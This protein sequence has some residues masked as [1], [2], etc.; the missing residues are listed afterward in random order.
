MD[1]KTSGVDIEKGKEFVEELKT[2]IP[3]I[4]GFN[5]RIC[6]EKVKVILFLPIE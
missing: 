1:Y 2:K 3:T 5:G 6:S 4:G